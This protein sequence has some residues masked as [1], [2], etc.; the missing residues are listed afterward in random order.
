MKLES[1]AFKDGE[2]IPSKYT[3]DGDN[4]II[5][6]KISGVHKNTISLALVL[7]D[8]DAPVG[9]WDHW[10]LWNIPPETKEIN[11]E[12]KV[13]HGK[14]SWGKQKYGGPCPPDKEHTYIF[15][16]YS[17]NTKLVLPEGSTKNQLEKAMEG[18]IIEK[19]ILKGRY[20]RK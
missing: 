8:P 14:N 12:L 16:L 19:A 1:P 17:L 6:L 4:S 9:I 13:P 15:T 10:I 20:N 3:C 11:D 18:H 2:S 7:D 5:P